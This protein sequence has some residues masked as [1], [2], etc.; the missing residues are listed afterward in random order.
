M[1]CS[2]RNLSDWLTF[3]SSWYHSTLGSGRHVTVTVSVTWSPTGRAWS[4]KGSTNLGAMF[5]SVS[6]MS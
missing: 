5:L 2:N 1:S 6:L 4:T 3:T